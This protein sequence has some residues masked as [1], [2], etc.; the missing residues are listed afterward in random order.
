[1]QGTE[2]DI[3]Q[4]LLSNK[5]LENVNLL[6]IESSFLDMR[7]IQ[8][9]DIIKKERIFERAYLVNTVYGGGDIVFSRLEES[10]KIA[11]E[12]GAHKIY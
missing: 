5:I 3:I 4:D 2:L 10:E 7:S 6:A 9:V 12:M 8:C 1:M 11:S